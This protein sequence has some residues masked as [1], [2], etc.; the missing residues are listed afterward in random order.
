MTKDE[1]SM[2]QLST[3]SS[4]INKKRTKKPTKKSTKDPRHM[5][6]KVALVGSAP[7]TLPLTPWRDESIEIWGL[8]WRQ[9]PRADRLFDMHPENFKHYARKNKPVDYIRELN[10]K[11]IPT[12]TCEVV[13]SLKCCVRYPIEEILKF[14][15]TNLDPFFDGDYFASS[16][17]YMICL[18]IYEDV[19]EIHL[20]G[21]DFIA[22]GEYEHQK[23][24]LEYLIGIARGRGIR[25]HVARGSALCEF[26]YRYGYQGRPWAGHINQRMLRERIESYEKTRE[27]S[28][29]KVRTLDG[30]IQEA[31]QLIDLIDHQERGGKLD[32][33]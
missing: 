17:S 6:R 29:A 7:S 33:D 22:K 3:D 31:K 14:F 20:Y 23:P 32:Y 18:A 12:Y 5:P 21:F 9:L 15:G 28:L 4:A 26:S 27:E 25:V 2:N 10:R 13:P 11:M 19:D 1:E 16:A 24:N 30:A 8:A